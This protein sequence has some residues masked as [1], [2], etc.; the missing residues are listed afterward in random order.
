MKKDVVAVGIG[1]VIGLLVY[2][3][4]KLAWMIVTF[5]VQLTLGHTNWY[6]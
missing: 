1:V 3:V 4:F 5:P 6:D 2:K